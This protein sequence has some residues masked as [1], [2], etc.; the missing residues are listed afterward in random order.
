MR[1]YAKPCEL[2][3]SKTA[4]DIIQFSTLS[5]CKPTFLSPLIAGLSFAL[6]KLY[7]H[8]DHT[9]RLD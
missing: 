9:G 3:G 4:T 5:N 7:L 1:W 6:M 2:E 8:A